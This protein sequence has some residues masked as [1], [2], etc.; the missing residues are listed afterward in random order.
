MNEAVKKI[1]IESIEEFNESQPDTKLNFD[2]DEKILGRNGKL[3]SLSFVMFTAIIEE[4]LFDEFDKNIYLVND[5]AF[6]QT[7]SPFYDIK[8]LAV[9]IEQLIN[10][11]E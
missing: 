6:S 3:D 5:K 9:F 10:E 7:R 1:L 11:E 8:S 2:E 4:K